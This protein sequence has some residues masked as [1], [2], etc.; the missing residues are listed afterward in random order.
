MDFVGDLG[1]HIL[2]LWP[3]SS[4]V[5]G[6]GMVGALSAKES[7]EQQ[8]IRGCGGRALRGTSH[9]PLPPGS[10]D[11]SG[12]LSPL[13]PCFLGRGHFLS[14]GSLPLTSA[15]CSEKHDPVVKITWAVWMLGLVCIVEGPPGVSKGQ[16]SPGH[17]LTSGAPG[18]CE[19]GYVVCL[20]C[21]PSSLPNMLTCVLCLWVFTS[22]STSN[23]GKAC[24]ELQ[25]QRHTSLKVGSKSE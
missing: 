24:G 1:P 5:G 14:F 25:V 11:I 7:R 20:P 19:V 12:V 17:G 2:L 22:S 9:L 4:C 23:V 10:K 15:Y 18:F 8:E 3:T 13:P 16:A 6:R 21:V